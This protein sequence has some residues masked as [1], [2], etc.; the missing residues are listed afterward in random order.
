MITAWGTKDG[1]A[2]VLEVCRYHSLPHIGEVP[3]WDKVKFIDE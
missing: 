2:T 3:E 1:V